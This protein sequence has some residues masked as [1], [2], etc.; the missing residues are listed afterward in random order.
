MFIFESGEHE[1]DVFVW[2]F[3][4]ERWRNMTLPM[5]VL[6]GVILA[7]GQKLLD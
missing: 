2:S 1:H 5:Q 4:E 7:L 6:F 3:A